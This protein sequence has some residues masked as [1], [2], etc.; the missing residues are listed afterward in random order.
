MIL[1]RIGRWSPAANFGTVLPTI[2]Q[3]FPQGWEN[4]RRTAIR[5]AT[6]RTVPCSIATCVVDRQQP[7]MWETELTAS[8]EHRGL[9]LEGLSLDHYSVSNKPQRA[10]T[11]TGAPRQS[12]VM[13]MS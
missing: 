3:L 4:V 11:D 10:H 8:N 7:G 12:E 1:R 6:N 5:S 9:E 13:A 2:A